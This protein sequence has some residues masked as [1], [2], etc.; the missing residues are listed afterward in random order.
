MLERLRFFSSSNLFDV[1]SLIQQ[2]VR[3]KLWSGLGDI[4][5]KTLKNSSASGSL[6]LLVRTH[7]K[8]KIGHNLV[9]R[10]WSYSVIINPQP[11]LGLLAPSY[12]FPIYKITN[13]IFCDTRTQIKQLFVF[14]FCTYLKYYCR[15]S[16]LRL[17]LPEFAI[18]VI[19][20]FGREKLA[21][22]CSN[23]PL[24]SSLDN[25]RGKKLRK[26]R[27]WGLNARGLCCL[28]FKPC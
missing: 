24:P 1:W 16:T 4:F 8:K 10:D 26:G 23:L 6:S 11:P 14:N 13:N 17:Y 19:R 28:V 7:L 21:Q 15:G 18:A 22:S 27:A 12:T 3:A 5:Y 9:T 2:N 25:F 20:Q